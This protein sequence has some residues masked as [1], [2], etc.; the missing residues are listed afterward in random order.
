MARCGIGGNRISAGNETPRRT[1]VHGGVGQRSY[2]GQIHLEPNAG[3]AR[4]VDTTYRMEFAV[5]NP[6]GG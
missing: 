6:P 3:F 5:G 4:H 1:R 2:A